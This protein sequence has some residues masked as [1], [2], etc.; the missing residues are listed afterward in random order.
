MQ[1][2]R[3]DRHSAF[4]W[5]DYFF[6]DMSLSKHKKDFVAVHETRQSYN[7]CDFSQFHCQSPSKIIHSQ[8][9]L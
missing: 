2:I 9:N 4:L 8:I 1:R 5:K 3:E 7:K 6:L